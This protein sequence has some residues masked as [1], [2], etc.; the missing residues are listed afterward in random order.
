MA[1]E[2][3]HAAPFCKLC[4]AI[5]YRNIPCLPLNLM[6]PHLTLRGLQKRE[7][8][9]NGK[10]ATDICT[11]PSVWAHPEAVK[12]AKPSSLESNPEV[13]PLSTTHGLPI[14]CIH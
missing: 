10:G 2:C 6:Q 14:I 11:K 1:A 9:A 3:L 4:I 8:S 12:C 7:T 5:L 13:S